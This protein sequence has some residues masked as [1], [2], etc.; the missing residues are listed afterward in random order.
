MSNATILSRH[1][2]DSSADSKSSRTTQL[3]N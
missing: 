1:M 3:I 2:K